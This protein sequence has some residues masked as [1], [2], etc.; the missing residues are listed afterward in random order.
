MLEVCTVCAQEGEVGRKKGAERMRWDR[1][2]ERDKGSNIGT[3][4]MTSVDNV[5]NFLTPDLQI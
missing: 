2:N 4:K 5:G 1:Q 3:E